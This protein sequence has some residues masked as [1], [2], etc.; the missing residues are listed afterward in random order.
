MEF[1][2]NAVV[3]VGLTSLGLLW[4]FAVVGALGVFWDSIGEHVLGLIQRLKR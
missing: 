4:T 2:Q 3:I 1:L